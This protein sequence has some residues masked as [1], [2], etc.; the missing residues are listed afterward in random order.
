LCLQHLQARQSQCALVCPARYLLLHHL[1][2][3]VRGWPVLL[4]VVAGLL[5]LLPHLLRCLA[6]LQ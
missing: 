2:C 1:L 3:P 6:L 5:L 4:V